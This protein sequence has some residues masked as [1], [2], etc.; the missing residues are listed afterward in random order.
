MLTPS[1]ATILPTTS[2]GLVQR[3]RSLP[4]A[5]LGN[6]PVLL[7]PDR[8]R[9]APSSASQIPAVV[10]AS[11]PGSRARSLTPP[12]HNAL[13]IG[14]CLVQPAVLAPVPV[15]AEPSPSTCGCTR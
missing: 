15:M 2:G 14:R 1:V 11:D 12:P 5:P 9:A 13:A 3:S 8:V 6:Q 10:V 4:P 7:P